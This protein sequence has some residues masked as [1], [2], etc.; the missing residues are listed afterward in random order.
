MVNVAIL[1][2]GVVGSGV[3]EVLDTNERHIEGKVDDLIRLKYILDVRDFPDSPFAGKVVHDFSVIEQDPEVSIV[4]E[5][6]GGAKV[7]L[8]FTR[9]ALQAGKSVITSNKELVAEHGCELLRLAQ[10]KGVSYLFEASVGGGI[11]IIRPLNQCLAANEIEEITGILNGT[12]NYILT[13]MIRAG[14]SF[15]DALREAQANGYAEQDPTADIE[16]H[17]ACRKI[18][19]LASL[20]FGRHIYPGRCPRRA[21]PASPWPT[22]PMPTPVERSSS[23]WGGLFAGPTGRCAP[24]WPHTWWTGRTPSPV[25]R[26]Y[27]TPSPYGATPS[28]T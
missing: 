8:D 14:L 6:I 12:T 25:W 22:W 21:S 24:M 23:C 3:A 9:R 15:G 17:D 28:A 10:E 16:G 4:V 13:R 18:C 1:G 2:F 11:P 7:A 26:M 27:S 20:A 19:I 5:T